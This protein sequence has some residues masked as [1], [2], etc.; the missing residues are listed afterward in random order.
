MSTLSRDYEYGRIVSVDVVTL[1][2]NLAA[3]AAIA[4]TTITVEDAADFDEDG[5]QL[6]LNAVVHTYAACDDDT[7]IISGLDPAL[8][9]AAVEGDDVSVYDPLYATVATD[10]V[11]QVAVIGDDGA[12]DMLECAIALHLIDA[13]DEGVRGDNGESVKLELDG[14]EWVVVDLR[15]LGDPASTGT[16]WARDSFTLGSAGAQAVTLTYDPIPTSED[17]KWNGLG[18]S[19]WTRSGRVVSLAESGLEVDDKVEVHYQRLGGN[20]GL[21]V[22]LGSFEVDTRSGST[23]STGLTL[24]TGVEHTLRVAGTYTLH[25]GDHTYGAAVPTHFPSPGG[26]G[27]AATDDVE[28]AYG[29]NAPGTYPQLFSPSPLEINLGAGWVAWPSASTEPDEGYQYA[30][31]VTGA[32]SA[33]QLRFVDSDY[34]DNDGVIRVSVY[35]AG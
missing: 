11:A 34:T 33:L 6:V 18:Q 20:V 3:D 25:N 22:L 12:V 7:G 23:V 21:G 10:K 14:G 9:V 29:F 28:W 15:G 27:Y 30:T 13:L 26:P 35:K 4:A 17:V 31:T 19:D 1:G 8:A 24:A 32:G 16:L 5:G 2:D